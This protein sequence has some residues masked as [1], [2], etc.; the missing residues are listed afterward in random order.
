M[1]S[2]SAPLNSF[3]P[4]RLDSLKMKKSE[5]SKVS[6]Q[7]VAEFEA[8]A[9][10][11]MPDLYGAAMKFTRNP[12]DAEDLFQE[13]YLKALKAWHQYEQGTNLKAWLS[14][15]MYNT[16]VNIYHK[17]NRDQAKES[18]DN[19]AEWQI[20]DAESLTST[21]SRSA[22]ALAIANMPADIVKEALKDL[23][24]EFREVVLQAIVMDLSYAEI[25]ENMGTPVGTVMS[26]LHR[27]KKELREKLAGYAAEQGIG[28]DPAN[29]KSKVQSKAKLEPQK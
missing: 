20:G 11:L 13:T 29:S 16:Y 17:K 27:G 2:I 21:T 4:P 10:P 7:S 3:A 19:L 1:V 9:V 6:K 25:A 5:D 12:T 26:R 22:E 18:I 23:K 15:I 28:T 14:K 8:Q 24:D